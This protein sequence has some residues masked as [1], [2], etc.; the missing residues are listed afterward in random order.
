M[1]ENFKSQIKIYIISLE[2]LDYEARFS[3]ARLIS[4]QTEIYVAALNLRLIL[5]SEPEFTPH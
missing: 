4:A 5:P 1:P 2:W 3:S